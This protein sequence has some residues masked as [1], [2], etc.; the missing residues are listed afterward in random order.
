ML[1]KPGISTGV[2]GHWLGKRLPA[3]K[4]G[5]K[6]IAWSTVRRSQRN[7]LINRGA[8]LL[9]DNRRVTSGGLLN[10]PLN[11]SLESV[12]YHR[13]P[14]PSSSLFVSLDFVC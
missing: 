1:R 8:Q 11:S 9:I 7:P 12:H 5:T 6:T 4:K 2:L 10:L 14:P 3:L 13:Y